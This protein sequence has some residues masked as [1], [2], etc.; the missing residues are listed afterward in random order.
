VQALQLYTRTRRWCGA[1]SITCR[2]A[3]VGPSPGVLSALCCTS[4]CALLAVVRGLPQHLPQ[5]K[6]C[7][8][9]GTV[10]TLSPCKSDMHNPLYFRSASHLQG[11]PKPLAAAVEPASHPVALAHVPLAQA[12]L[13]VLHCLSAQQLAWCLSWLP[14]LPVSSSQVGQCSACCAGP[15]QLATGSQQTLG[16]FPLPP[17]VRVEGWWSLHPAAAVAKSK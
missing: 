13:D 11:C 15:W 5:A 17:P 14:Q 7:T 1:A 10:T 8:I 16:C 6:S 3:A 4:C 2:A 9:S 12:R